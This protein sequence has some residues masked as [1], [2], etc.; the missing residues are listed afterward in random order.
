VNKLQ[1]IV[2]NIISLATGGL[3]TRLLFIITELIIARSMGA[4]VFGQF[5]T[6]LAYTTIFGSFINFGVDFYLVKTIS[7]KPYTIEWIF[8]NTLFIKAA[9]AIIVYIFMILLAIYLKYSSNIFLLIQIFG[10]YNVLLGF[11]ETFA[12]LFQALEKMEKIAFYRLAQIVATIAFIA[13]FLKKGVVIC[14][15]V[16]LSTAS[17]FTIFW[18]L[19]AIKECRPKLM[20]NKFIIIIK[21][22]YIYGLISILFIIY[23]RVDTIMLSIMRSEAEV[24]FYSAAYKF[25]DVFSKVPIILSLAILPSL[26][27]YSIKDKNKAATIYRV[28]IRYLALFGLPLVTVLFIYAKSFIILFFGLDYLMAVSAL[29]VLCWTLFLSFMTVPAGNQLLASDRQELNLLV[30]TIVVILNLGLNLVLI[31]SYGIVGAAWATLIGQLI[32][33]VLLSCFYWRINHSKPVF[34]DIIKPFIATLTFAVPIYFWQNELGLICGILLSVCIF[35]LVII[36][37]KYFNSYDLKI[38]RMLMNRKS[39][40]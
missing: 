6:A 10:F 31:P 35:F 38:I 3:I 14:A 21:N 18:F 13:M 8:G 26:Y 30:W 12:S 2:K 23:Y 5:S 34:T 25:I 22:S 40:A 20:V 15:I 29:K 33:F 36:L 16:Y 17:V 27:Q 7:Q 19:D 24:G 11:Q 37:L 28:S 4:E 32:A 39:E 9:C 1:T